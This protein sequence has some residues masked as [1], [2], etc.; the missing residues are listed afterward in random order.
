MLSAYGNSREYTAEDISRRAKLHIKE[1]KR[2]INTS[3][4]SGMLETSTISNG[5]LTVVVYKLNHYGVAAA[6]VEKTS[7]MFFKS[8]RLHNG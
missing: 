7:R 3:L 1:A 8:A 6:M 2:Q 5:G 4:K